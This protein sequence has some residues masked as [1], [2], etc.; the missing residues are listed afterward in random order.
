MGILIEITCDECKS[1]ISEDRVYCEDC[2]LEL[3]DKI[4]EL[5]D[6][7]AALE[8]VNGDLQIEIDELIKRT[9]ELENQ[10]KLEKALNKGE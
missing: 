4:S 10:L 3:E 9:D 6:E 5:E 2:Y 8:K 1:E 7:K